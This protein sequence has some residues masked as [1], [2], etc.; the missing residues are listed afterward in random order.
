MNLEALEQECLS[1]LKQVTNPL[2][3]LRHLLRHLRD[4]PDLADFDEQDLIAFLRNH[5]LFRIIEPLEL[6]QGIHSAE[7]LTQL[8]VDREP[9]IILIT[10]V[11]TP[12]DLL[13]MAKDELGRM[14]EVLAK[15][16]EETR[17]EEDNERSDTILDLLARIDHIAKRVDREF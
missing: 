4:K 13:N 12:Q 8:G 17:R 16:L 2:V 15:A 1:Y 7:A 3:P 11:P 10:R 14:R 9:S 5:E 6:P